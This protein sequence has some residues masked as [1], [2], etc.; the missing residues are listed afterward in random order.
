MTNKTH[1]QVACKKSTCIFCF[2]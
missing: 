2:K 1:L